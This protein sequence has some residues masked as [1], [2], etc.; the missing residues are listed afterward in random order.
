MRRILKFKKFESKSES[1]EGIK[2]YF[3]DICD[4]F[5][6]EISSD[7]GN[8]IIEVKMKFDL[9]I[10]E[11]FNMMEYI[12][13]SIFKI[14]SIGEFKTCDIWRRGDLRDKAWALIKSAVPTTG[15]NRHTRTNY[16]GD[17]DLENL[18]WLKTDILNSHDTEITLYHGNINKQSS[19]E[20]EKVATSVTRVIGI[21]MLF[22]WLGDSKSNESIQTSYKEFRDLLKIRIE[23]QNKDIFDHFIEL[24]DDFLVNVRCNLPNSVRR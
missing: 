9:S 1:V 20:Y 21:N 8:H 14:R 19:E 10:D 2:D 23:E 4:D 17:D 18:D 12:K 16:L 7:I 24:E 5:D 22:N 6:V 3:L 11:F 15:G 13:N